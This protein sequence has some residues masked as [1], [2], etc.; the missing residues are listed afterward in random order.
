MTKKLFFTFVI[1]ISVCSLLIIGFSMNLISSNQTQVKSTNNNQTQKKFRYISGY[2]AGEY[3]NYVFHSSNERVFKTYNDCIGCEP[4]EDGDT[5]LWR[6]FMSKKD[7]EDTFN[8]HDD[9]DSPWKIVEGSV[10]DKNGVKRKIVILRDESR[11]VISVRILWI[12]PTERTYTYW[13]IGAPS[14][15]IAKAFEDSQIFKKYT[16]SIPSNPPDCNT[17]GVNSANYDWCK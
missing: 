17:Y 4:Y 11:K 12:E 14:V 10:S 9:I 2:D 16:K 13:F 7:A 15:E 6:Q 8:G 5:H 1:L 3:I